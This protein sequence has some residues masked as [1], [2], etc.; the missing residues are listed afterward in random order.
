MYRGII[1]CLLLI[2]G[3]A[4]MVCPQGYHFVEHPE[5]TQMEA[6]HELWAYYVAGVVCLF[7]GYRLTQD[8]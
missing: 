1:G 3:F 7:C 6:L 2:I 8:V 5:W 4:L